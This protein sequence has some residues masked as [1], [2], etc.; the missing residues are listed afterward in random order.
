MITNSRS[1]RVA[2][3]VG[4][5]ALVCWLLP[6]IGTAEVVYYYISLDK[7]TITEGALPV[8]DTGV[9]D[10]SWQRQRAIGSEMHP[11]VAM[12]A[13]DADAWLSYG[14][15]QMWLPRRPM[16]PETAFLAVRA[17]G[18]PPLVGTLFC[19][20]ADWS[21]MQ[22]IRFK[23]TEPPTD[24]AAN[25]EDVLEAKLDHYRRLM[26]SGGSGTAWFR[27]QVRE[28]LHELGREDEV[29]DS[30]RARNLGNDMTRT[31]DLFTG[32]RALSEN[33]QLDR[34]LFVRETDEGTSPISS[35]RG[36]T[37]EDYDWTKEIEGKTP[38]K[39]ALASYIPADDV[40]A[41]FPSLRAM[42]Q[43]IDE[44]L[45]RGGAAM[46][47]AQMRA[48]DAQTL[49]RYEQQL[50]MP[51]NDATAAMG[52]QFVK[53]V[54]VVASDPYVRTGTAMAVLFETKSPAPFRAAL[55]TQL[56]KPSVKEVKED[57]EGVSIHGATSGD[58]RISAYVAELDGVVVLSN[59]VELLHKIIETSQF[60]DGS[61]ASAPEFTFFRD[62]YTLGDA[63]ESGF[64]VLTDAAIRK[65]CSPAW[66][67]GASRRT[68]AMA[69]MAELQAAHLRELVAGEVEKPRVLKNEELLTGLGEVTLTP[70]GVESSR[71]G[72]I[73]F[74]TP[75]LHLDIERVTADEKRAYEWWRD[76]YQRNWT[77]R[78]DPIA[79]RLTLREDLLA[80]DLTV[81]PL[82]TRS[83]Y[84][85]FMQICGDTQLQPGDGDPHAG[86]LVHFTMAMD[87]NSRPVRQVT[88]FAAQMAP[89]I[90]TNPLN[91]VGRWMAIYADEDPF[92]DD[93]QKAAEENGEN[94]VEDFLESNWPR[95]PV[96]IEIE[97]V[98]GLKLAAFMA[99][100]RAWIE[101][102][103]PGMTAWE[104][105]EYAGMSYVRIGATEQGRSSMGD[106]IDDFALYYAPTGKALILS[107][108]EQQ[109]QKALKRQAS[110]A[111][112]EKET[113]K[114]V[115][116]SLPGK[117]M[118]F[119]A[120][121]D[122]YRSFQRLTSNELLLQIQQSSWRNLAILNE[123]HREFGAQ[124]S[125]AFMELW[126]GVR[127]ICPGGGD[128]IWN[129]EFQTYE[130]TVLGCPA[131]HPEK[132]PEDALP[133]CEF[134]HGRLGLTF[135]QDGLRAKTELIKAGAE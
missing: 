74:L 68:R 61:V 121:Q 52:D 120:T 91:W 78:F 95:L 58:W 12:E 112:G 1:A 43:C 98:N 93:M 69:A 131:I 72:S 45:H 124:D 108:N 31:F 6:A 40:A 128:F 56:M 46:S 81:R 118:V 125:I 47:L 73:G 130:S 25:R 37:V 127:P 99:A 53:S 106:D 64:V 20:K 21:G 24:S 63:D 119:E 107:L 70:Q 77:R 102:T 105:L 76:G 117:S 59:S 33:L 32:G 35:L 80:T 75:I 7:L 65:I 51:L 4:I 111:E 23:I 17:S 113:P 30:G 9:E 126:W 2:R 38:K 114:A 26:R 86:S 54:A 92:W 100:L 71:Y 13:E 10:M 19:P 50:G 135:E 85:E 104:S 96:V 115:V 134:A 5:L 36:I 103:A 132:A 57:F 16:H 14:T 129:E 3:W 48:E 97:S 88:N 18:E 55:G 11:Y 28:T 67:I 109:I 66:R 79:V 29:V 122:A 44:G 87:P 42:K 110:P 34:D 89:N 84:R 27:H 116:E 8:T 60:P 123:W 94:G 62:R 133:L 101:Q 90:G 83:N 22:A 41:F 39:D 15:G 82:I 49:S